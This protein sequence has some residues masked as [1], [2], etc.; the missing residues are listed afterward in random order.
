MNN[1]FL[2]GPIQTGKSTLIRQVLRESPGAASGR[3]QA[4]GATPELKGFTCQRVLGEEGQL[5]GFALG[6]ADAELTVTWHRGDAPP[7]NV[8]KA[9]TPEGTMVDLSVFENAGVRYIREAL[10]KAADGA[11]ADGCR[12]AL[13]LL[14]EIGGH[15]MACEPFRDA[16][17]EILDSE[18]TCIGVLK[19]RNS[20][21]RMDPSIVELNDELRKR[22]MKDENSRVLYFE[23]DESGEAAQEIAKSILDLLYVNNV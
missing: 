14:D 16:L 15:E 18:L 7:E 3:K 4:S 17:H 23:R 19:L 5:L 20:A 8:F 9:F 22:I 1:L 12:R 10:G 13:V 11:G 6:P 2:E 21:E